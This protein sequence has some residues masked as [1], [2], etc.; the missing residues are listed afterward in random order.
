M[1]T[2]IRTILMWTGVMA[3][4][5][6]SRRLR[7]SRRPS[8]EGLDS[9]EVA[10][11]YDWIS[12]MPQF[13]FLRALVVRELGKYQPSDT[14]LDM[15]CGPGYLLGELAQ[16]FP[17]VQLLGIDISQE[18]VETAARNLARRGAAGR[19]EF[20]TGNIQELPLDE[21]TVDFAVS[22]LSLHHWSDPERALAQVHRALRP[23]G[24][25]LLFD[26]RRD[27]RRWFYWF[28]RLVTALVVPAPLRHVKEPL[29][30]LLSS[31]TPSELRSILSS[32]PFAEWTIQPGPIWI[33]VWAR[34]ENIP[35]GNT[36]L[37]GTPTEEERKAETR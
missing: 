34:K 12:R 28:F 36:V 29:G 20:R 11:A 24:Q 14:I 30:S 4:V 37:I 25:M 15:G 16:A 26:L 13:R 5:L 10:A 22:S 3:L 33:F 21:G 7:V 8:L 6:G 9:P 19:I 1:K 32:A 31:Y 35:A 17:D 18:M 23:G 27:V 2:S